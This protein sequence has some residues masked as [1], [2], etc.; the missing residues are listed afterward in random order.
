MH[1]FAILEGKIID[2]PDVES[3]QEKFGAG[4]QNFL[5]SGYRAVT[6]VPMM[7][8]DAAVGVLSVVRL[9]P[10][11][12]S[13]EQFEMLR[14]F[15]QQAVIAIENTRLVNELRQTNDILEKV[16]DQLAKYIS[17][18]LYQSIFR[19]EQRVAIG[20]TR[21]KLTIFFSDIAGFTEI[22]DQLEPEE[23]TS[24][25]N[26]YLT[27]MSRIAQAYGAYFD[28]FIGDA[29]MFYFGDPETKGVKEDAAACVHMAIDMQQRLRQLQTGWQ[30]R[31]LIDR[32]FGARMGINTGYCTV[33]NFGSEDRMDYTIIGR[34]VNLAARLEAHADPGGILM[35]AETYSLVKDWVH[36]KEQEALSVKGFA[37]PVRTFSAAGIYAEQAEN[38]RW[39]HHEDDGVTINID[40]SRA[41]REVAREALK[42]A[43][44][45]L[46]E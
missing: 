41:D 3:A 19:G 35:A 25:L 10:G 15:A 2:F 38:P 9:S 6:M 31:G 37:K 36:A 5:A 12:L 45:Y 42:K 32:S 44:A 46:D 26:E 16:S 7:R 17:P 27:E 33:G 22:T 18:Q 24:L 39:F 14:T 21:K 8:D 28:K 43:L 4:A 29:M 20:S 23:L 1:G 13:N 30:E 11:P 40:G 34:E